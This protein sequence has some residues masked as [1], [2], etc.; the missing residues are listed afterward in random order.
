M[1]GETHKGLK[2]RIRGIA[3][4]AARVWEMEKALK[5]C[6]ERLRAQFESMP[7]PTYVWQQAGDDFVLIDCNNAAAE[8]THGKIHGLIGNQAGELYADHPEVLGDFRQ[9]FE[10]RTVV[11]READFR[12]KTTGEEKSFSVTYA[13]VSPD[14]VLVHTE[15]ITLRKDAEAALRR[16]RNHLEELVKTRTAELAQA[17]WN[18]QSEI[19]ERRR[20]EEECQRQREAYFA[21]FESSPISLWVEDCSHMKACVDDLPT[22][23]VE[24]IRS[25]FQDHP[26]DVLRCSKPMKI[27]D[28]NKQGLKLFEASTKEDLMQNT[29]RIFGEETADFRKEKLVLISQGRYMFDADTITRTLTGKLKNIQLRCTAAPGYE[30][31][32]ERVFVSVLDITERKQAEERLRESEESYRTLA[33]NLPGIV[34]RVH[35]REQNRMEFFNEMLKPMTGY[36]VEELVV[37]EVCRIEPIIITEDRESVVAAVEDAIRNDRPFQVE[38]RIRHKNGEIRHFLERGRP[39]RGLDGNP[40]Y[41]DGVIFDITDRKQAEEALAESEQRFRTIVETAQE[42]IWVLD[43]D[44][45]TSYVNQRLSEMLGYSPQ[46]MLGRHLHDFMDEEGGEQAR[47]FEE[48]RRAG[49]REIHEFRFVRKNGSSV[50]TL[51][52]TNPFFDHKGRYTGALGMLTDIT[53]RKRWE[54]TL[55]ESESKYAA[56]VE[57]ARDGVFM[58]ADEKVKF[59]NQALAK[60]CGYE[61]EEIIEMPM[62]NLIAPEC[63]DQITEVYERRIAGKRPPTI[64]ECKGLRKD[65]TVIDIEISTTGIVYKGRLT[66]IGIARDITERKKT[67]AEVFKVQ[68]LE[69]VGILAGGIAH[70]FNDL[71]VAILGN[72]TLAKLNPNIPPELAQMLQEAERASLRAKDLTAQLITFASGGAPVKKRVDLSRFLEDIGCS[73]VKESNVRCDVRVSGDLWPVEVDEGQTTQLISSLIVNAQHAMPQGGKI[74]VRAENEAVVPGTPLPLAPGNYVKISLQDTGIGIPREFLTR[75]FDPYFTTK[76]RGSGLGLTI[77]YAIVRS[78]GGHIYIESELGA[79]T[80][81]FIYLPAGRED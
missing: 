24:D 43:A 11:R 8:I 67:E 19:A 41:I 25:Y 80:T 1:S 5:N 45:N 6:D 2:D 71:L 58:V 14:L 42:G 29:A 59:A 79:G 35:C 22:K 17:N 23:G 36:I 50:W 7:V 3:E 75:V 18:L 74:E 57:Q 70:D 77:A 31:T 66:E 78:H 28:V 40:M 52:S 20:T 73:A 69:S 10:S 16:S 63:R 53:D 64:F 54:G 72:I 9:C 26:E 47:Q 38:Y 65:G 61:P 51:I 44:H 33:E 13:F 27:K 39:A 62:L 55:Q 60:M 76:Q 68:K 81:V 37:A 21:L 4:K 12:L 30:T 34:Y 49:I 15:D 32:L 48:R 56:L 46:E